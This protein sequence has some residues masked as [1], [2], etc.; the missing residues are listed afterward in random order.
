MAEN[1]IKIVFKEG[2][3]I[4]N[5]NIVFDRFVEDVIDFII[6]DEVTDDNDAYDYLYFESKWVAPIDW[7][8]YLVN[9]NDC[10]DYIIG[11]SVEFANDYVECFIIK[12]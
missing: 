4:E 5:K 6:P 12:K 1:T 7:M 9:K 11:V 8:Q 3:T 2:T 10:I